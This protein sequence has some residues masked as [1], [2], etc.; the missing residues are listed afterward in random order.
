LS[1]KDVQKKN[2][3]DPA[4]DPALYL[5][6]YEKM[7]AKMVDSDPDRLAIL[8]E[9]A[10]DS[11]CEREVL[12]RAVTAPND[13]RYA[14]RFCQPD[15]FGD[16][17]HRRIFWAIRKLIL[18]NIVPFDQ[19]SPL[20]VADYLNQAGQLSIVGGPANVER[21]MT[22]PVN[23]ETGIIAMTNLL[24]T[25]RNERKIMAV[26]LELQKKA[27]DGKTNLS[28]IEFVGTV[29]GAANDYRAG[30]ATVVGDGKTLREEVG[31]TQADLLRFI[32]YDPNALVPTPW[33]SLDSVLGGL[34]R[35]LLVV[36]G[37]RPG[38]GK[39]SLALQMMYEI[40]RTSSTACT[41]FFTLEMTKQQLMRRCISQIC[42]VLISS[43]DDFDNEEL[44]NF[45]GMLPLISDR[46]IWIDSDQ[47]KTKTVTEMR[48]IIE[49]WKRR[50][51]DIK[52]AFFDH[53]QLMRGSPKWNSNRVAEIAEISG[54]VKELSKEFDMLVVLLSQ[55]S[56]PN[57]PKKDNEI[58]PRPTMTDLRESGS[59]EQDADVIALIHRPEYYY[60]PGADIPQRIRG[61]LEL[62]VPK[63]RSGSPGM[64]RLRWRGSYTSA[65]EMRPDEAALAQ[66]WDEGEPV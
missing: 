1:K 43:I 65:T 21:I 24:R 50:G 63:N 56:R 34:Y 53:A 66:G 2:S 48:L 18:D 52:A 62:L 61:L 14:I 44:P 35:K 4:S 47:L 10:F 54:G 6:E 57:K 9:Q 3:N 17:H 27:T 58:P 40:L 36:L 59:L 13:M 33:P 46:C 31:S 64:A 15:D 37:G 60:N 20:V 23:L 41:I 49:Q 12:C 5:E 42:E 19:V 8:E 22:N 39:T 11:A 25:K 51:Y 32:K 16:L 29:I 55:L 26:V 45:A 30:M 38:M 7:F 28:P